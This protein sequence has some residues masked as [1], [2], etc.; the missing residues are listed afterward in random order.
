MQISYFF[1]LKVTL[2]REVTITRCPGLSKHVEVNVKECSVLPVALTNICGLMSWHSPGSIRE[3]SQRHCL[4]FTPGKTITPCDEL[5]FLLGRIYR[6]W[7]SRA[8]SVTTACQK[9]HYYIFLIAC[10]GR[11]VHM[12]G[13]CMTMVFVMAVFSRA[14]AW[15]IH[16]STGDWLC[17][18]RFHQ[19]N[20]SCLYLSWKNK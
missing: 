16:P 13:G 7:I 4:S 20:E 6:V 1:S 8:D 14:R 5:T 11:A 19:V 10:T 18:P 12:L 2:S 15:S 9:L 3:D 17:R